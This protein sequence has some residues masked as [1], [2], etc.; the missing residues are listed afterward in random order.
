MQLQ[1]KLLGVVKLLKPPHTAFFERPQ[2]AQG[3]QSRQRERQWDQ[4][5]GRTGWGRW[6]QKRG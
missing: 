1:H 3:E 2:R 6:R 5:K 4:E